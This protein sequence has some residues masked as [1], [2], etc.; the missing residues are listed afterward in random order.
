MVRRYILLSVAIALSAPSLAAAQTM[1]FADS[2]GL[3]ASSCGADITANCRGVNLD[4]NRLKEC[5]SRNQDVVSA[6]CKATY[7]K[8][9]EA[10]QKRIA[11]RVTVANACQREI[12]KLCGGSTK[13]TSKS[14][15]C[16]MTASGVGARC[17][18]SLGEAGY[19]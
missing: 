8:A 11:A 3:I 2:A 9:F 10:I 12:V 7:F 4:S 18:Q 5:L 14:I 16:L 6:Q 13:E 15:P 1:S 17:Q 19:R